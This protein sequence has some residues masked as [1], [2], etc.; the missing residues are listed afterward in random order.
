ML[1]SPF[2]TAVPVEIS[3]DM[4][5]HSPWLLVVMVTPLPQPIMVMVTI[6]PHTLL[7]PPNCWLL[8]LQPRL[9]APLQ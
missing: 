7:L 5:Y 9:P 4:P 8:P 2:Y 1:Y 6:P 3:T